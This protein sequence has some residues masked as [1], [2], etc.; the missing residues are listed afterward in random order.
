MVAW[1]SRPELLE[2]AIGE[3]EEIIGKLETFVGGV[4]LIG[5]LSRRSEARIISTGEVLSSTI[6]SYAFNAEGVSCRL[7]D[8]RRMIITDD[9]YISAQPDME[10]TEA[11]V[12]RIV[13][14][15]SKGVDIVLTQGFIASTGAGAP[16][17][18]GFEGCLFEQLRSGGK[19]L[20]RQV[21]MP[22]PKPGK[23]CL[24]VIIM[25]SLCLLCKLTKH[26]GDLG[27]C[28]HHDQRPFAQSAPYDRD[29]PPDRRLILDGRAAEFHH[30]HTL[31]V[32]FVNSLE[33]SYVPLHRFLYLRDQDIFLIRVGREDGSRA[34]D[35]PHRESVQPRGIAPEGCRL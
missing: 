7:I 25:L 29:H 11:N 5:E 17:V 8:A 10:T 1:R 19:Q 9:N 30:N 35:G 3:V 22:L 21:K 18:L 28:R 31:S 26:P 33:Y 23:Q 12:R 6:I 20:P 16:S 13:G 32:K 14:Q 34:A 15:E 4:C 24:H 2:E 27:Q